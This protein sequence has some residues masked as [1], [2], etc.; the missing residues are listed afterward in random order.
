MAPIVDSVFDAPDLLA[1]HSIL[2][3][4]PLVPLADFIRDVESF[5]NSVPQILHVS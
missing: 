4:E 1:S 3:E 5:V 2:D